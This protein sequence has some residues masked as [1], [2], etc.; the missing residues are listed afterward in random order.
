MTF[1]VLAPNAPLLVPEPANHIEHQG[2]DGAEQN[3][4][5]EWKVKGRVFSSIENV[6]RKAAHGKTGASKEQEKAS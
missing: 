1:A 6:A 3:G 5:C 2:N 4:S